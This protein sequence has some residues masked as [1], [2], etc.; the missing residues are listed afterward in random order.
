M[1]IE[2]L[3]HLNKIKDFDL[4]PF[5]DKTLSNFYSID[6][7]KLKKLSKPILLSII[8]NEHLKIKIEDCLFDFIQSILNNNDDIYDI[9]FYEQICISFLSENLKN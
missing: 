6:E 8:S 5:I 3:S 1:V 4:S 7:N 9:D 2:S